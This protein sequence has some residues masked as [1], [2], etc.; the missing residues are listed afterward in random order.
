[1]IAPLLLHLIALYPAPGASGVCPDSPL[2]LSFDSPARLGA[3]GTIRIV[4]L[5]DG[6]AVDTIDVGAPTAVQSIGGLPGFRY[7]PVIA[8][9]SEVSVYPR[10]GSLTYGHR[11]AVEITPG[12]FAGSPGV[13]RPAWAFE[14]RTAPPA[15]A[16]RYTVAADGSGDFC[17]IQGALDFIPDGNVR[18][19]TIF[20][21]AG[22]YT[23]LVFF[24]NK[25]AITLRGEDRRR[26]ILQYANND[27]FNRGT[28]NP[29]VSG[30]H[31]YHRGVLLA[32]RAERFTLE[33]LTVR[34]TTAHGGSQAEAIIFN[35]TTA[36]KA[37][38]KDVDLYSFQ[39][40]LQI[41]GQ[42]Y[43]ENA[44]VEGDV[45]FLWGNGPSFF[46]NCTF[47]SVSSGR[48]YTQVRNPASNHGF[49]FL[50]CVFDGAAG[51]TGN[52]LSRI[53]PAR[54]PASEVVLLDCTLGPSVGPVGWLLQAKPGTAGA[55]APASIR[56]WEW[57][58]HDVAGRPADTS[59]RLA[60]SRRLREPADASLIDSY[61]NPAWVLGGWDG[62]AAARDR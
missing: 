40:T 55:P 1:M 59:G 7:Y 34:N 24:A 30:R 16:A 15:G 20:V 35:G 14:T 5:A 2:R 54:F 3:S 45:D 19:V 36:A 26:T 8:R 56:F 22:T 27:R 58:S 53:E 46:E 6:R 43:I 12:A 33:N 31:I 51:V 47:R 37:V 61:R 32:Q 41:N 23:E 13:A 38:V 9:G 50:H 60:G 11:Y 62:R 17:T 25:N 44:Y 49:V 4:D 10:N 52:Y 42:C 21:R 29:Y 48:Y 28:G 18:P 57:N 39:D